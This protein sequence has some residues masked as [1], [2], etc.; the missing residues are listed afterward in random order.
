MAEGASAVL[1]IKTPLTGTPDGAFKDEKTFYE[2]VWQQWQ[3][4]SA[5]DEK[6]LSRLKKRKS[7]SRLWKSCADSKKN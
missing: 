2:A 1:G 4:L 6:I 3:H 7:G 5:E